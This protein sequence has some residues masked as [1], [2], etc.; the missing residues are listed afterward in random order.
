MLSR[1]LA[2]CI[3]LLALAGLAPA[4]TLPANVRAHKDVVYATFAGKELKLDIYTPFGETEKAIAAPALLRLGPAR[5]APAGA[6][7][8]LLAQG[9]VLAYAAYLPEDSGA[10]AFS[11]FPQD[12]LAAKAAIRY[13][14]G[15]ADT[16]QID[17]TRIGIWG[18]GHG[19]T[20][21]ALAAFTADQKDLNGT[22]GDFAGESS[23]VRAV[24]LFEGITDW[25]NAELFGD[26]YVNFPASP[27]YQ[28]FGGNTKEFPDAARQ[29]SAVNYIRPTSPATLMV[30][31]ASDQQRA[32]HLIFAETLRKTGVPSA[33][34]E[35]TSAADRVDESRLN[36]TVLAFFDDTLKGDRGT[37][38]RFTLEQEVDSLTA[39]GLFKQ[40]RRLVDE[41]VEALTKSSPAATATAA[42]LQRSP[43]LQK[44]R[45]INELQQ[46]P[47][48]QQL[49]EARKAG[50][51]A[52]SDG[53]AN[54]AART[55][56][57][58]RE[59]L[60]DP[61]RISQY[62]VEA[63]V[64]QRVYDGRADALRFVETL[65]SYL[66]K[67]DARGA[68]Q[69]ANVM[70]DIAR[71]GDADPAILNQFLARYD[72]LKGKPLKIF[73]PGIGNVL[74][75]G[76]YGQD[77]YGYWMDFKAGG[78]T[79]R[80][81]FIPPGHYTRG[82]AREEWGRL[83]GEP[84][85]EPTDITKG[86]WLGE[87]AVT[88]GLYEAVMGAAENHSTFRVTGNNAEVRLKLPVENVSYAHAVNF[89]SK[90]GVDARLPTDAEWEY[91]CRAGSNY[92]YAGTGRLSDMAWFW[93]EKRDANG[94]VPTTSAPAV[95]DSGEVDVRILHDLEMEQSDQARLTHPVKQKLPNA[96]G[97]YDMQGNVW[98]WC[99]GT[100]PDRPHDYHPVKGGSWISIPQSCRAA[101]TTWLPV[102]QQSWNLGLRI[103]I[104][105][106]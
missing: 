102:E 52:V 23:A 82:S 19:A 86:F 77:L 15:S 75:A 22:L 65:N 46:A 34:Y 50:S 3:M 66:L 54:A 32:M 17:K 44:L 31:L 39:A 105:A 68:D 9:Y 49:A 16:L 60:T 106:Q 71:K 101:R 35:D 104:S 91:A 96:W 30:T 76:D 62:A 2:A 64:P 59:V 10:R 74:F 8:D 33:L 20:I 7:V 57:T 53:A 67:G 1:S 42:T 25:R 87:S 58:I 88:Q 11:K 90:L 40:A 100:S 99:A 41:Q 21:A 72:Q 79:Q 51:G 12:L 78:A 73:P 93:D 84:I 26:E 103:C 95:S 97:L 56:W 98:Q 61:E 83:P 47:A 70:R 81:R 43:W 28:L 85:L 6:A 4:Q 38:R 18:A 37:A 69:Q 45:T 36:R 29:A 48:L 5:E 24:C 92:M 80:L 89:L 13:V 55:L 14:R 27:A 63:T 94:Q